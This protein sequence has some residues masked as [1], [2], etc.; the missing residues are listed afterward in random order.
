MAAG[1]SCYVI[2]S[3]S[4]TCWSPSRSNWPRRLRYA[5]ARAD[6]SELRSALIVRYQ[7]LVGEDVLDRLINVCDEAFL[8]DNEHYREACDH[9]LVEYRQAAFRRPALAGQSY[10]ADPQELRELLDGYLAGAEYIQTDGAGGVGLLSPH[11]DYE[12]GGPV[13][14]AVWKRAAEMARQADL[15][16]M[17]G[18]DHYGGRGSLTLTHQHYATP[19]GV[20]PTAQDAVDAVAEAIGPEAAFAEE[21]HHRNEHSIELATVWL[22]HMRGG[23]PCEMVPVLCGGFSHFVAGLADPARDPAVEAFIDALRQATKG[24]RVLVVAAG[25]LSHVG[26][27]F[28]GQPQGAVERAQVNAADQGIIEQMCR[29][30]APGF[31]AAI[32]QIG[33]RNNVCGLPPVYLALRLMGPVKGEQVS[34]DHCPA[35]EQNASFVSVGGVIFK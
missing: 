35:D 10:P 14:A 9:R 19:F 23:E 34:Y 31:F 2:L 5:M 8:L 13:Y 21:L 4:A 25:D 1:R 11:I 18:T 16:I 22:H 32:Q 17:L 15:A 27:A 6:R 7:L 28:G 29:G 30:D 3:N 33:D 26:P 24:R 20:L 12:R